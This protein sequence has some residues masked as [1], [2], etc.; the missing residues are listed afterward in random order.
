MTMTGDPTL[1]P[2]DYVDM[3][4]KPGVFPDISAVNYRRWDAVNQSNLKLFDGTAYAGHYHMTHPKPSTK[5]MLV[6]EAVHAAILEPKRFRAQYTCLPHFEGNHN[7]N[8]Y[9]AKRAEW[10]AGNSHKVIIDTA[11]DWE[12]VL[13]MQASFFGGN[14]TEAEALVGCGSHEVSMIW[15]D[16]HLDTD[17]IG[18]ARMDVL[19]QHDGWSVVVDIKSTKNIKNFGKECENYGYPQQAWWYLRGLACL[20][21]ARRRFI[22]IAIS[23]EPP[24][25]VSIRE[26]GEAELSIGQRKLTP[27]LHKIIHGQQTGEWPSY[28]NSIEPLTLPAWAY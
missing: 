11:K 6:G 5:S 26:M 20:A 25:E 15:N 4:A 2:I 18:K 16:N 9:K 10:E 1:A 12:S 21:P 14:Y 3:P 19:G 22:I 7:S 24:Y 27:C 28:P 8:A 13:G 17:F 23:T